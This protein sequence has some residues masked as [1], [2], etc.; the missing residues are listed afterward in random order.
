MVKIFYK[1]IL[2]Q[3][4][5][6][7]GYKKEKSKQILLRR[8]P[9]KSLGLISGFLHLDLEKHKLLEQAAVVA[10]NNQ[11]NSV[12]EQLEKLYSHCERQDLIDNIRSEIKH[13]EKFQH[14]IKKAIRYPSFLTFS[15]RR[16]IQEINKYVVEQARLYNKI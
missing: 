13:I 15:E 5:I 16:M 6:I 1:D 10:L 4:M 11:E 9:K 7:E 3:V 8:D 2:E 12:I 14:S